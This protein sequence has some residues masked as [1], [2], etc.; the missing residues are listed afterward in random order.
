LELMILVIAKIY[1][2]WRRRK[3]NT[4]PPIWLMP[5]CVSSNWI[6]PSPTTETWFQKNSPNPQEEQKLNRNSPLEE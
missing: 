2:A 3:R 5:A 4:G 6:P 1:E